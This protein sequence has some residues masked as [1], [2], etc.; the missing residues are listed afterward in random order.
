[1]K[2]HGGASEASLV[3][4]A[5][6]AVFF[7]SFDQRQL[8]NDAQ[9]IRQAISP[10]LEISPARKTTT[11]APRI[12][13]RAISAFMTSSIDCARPNEANEI[14]GTSTPISHNNRSAYP[15]RQVDSPI[16]HNLQS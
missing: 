5:A 6:F 8:L 12:C 9:H 7:C 1:M 4:I 10:R 16:Q 14:A 2:E 11:A 3:A 15:A 13:C